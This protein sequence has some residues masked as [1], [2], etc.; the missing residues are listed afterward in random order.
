MSAS[1]IA[2]LA[3]ATGMIGTAGSPAGGIPG[4]ISGTGRTARAA[5]EDAAS[6]FIQHPHPASRSSA[7]LAMAIQ[8][9]RAQVF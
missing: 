9:V 6:V 3:G 7:G 2:G 4:V 8:E 5:L 1:A